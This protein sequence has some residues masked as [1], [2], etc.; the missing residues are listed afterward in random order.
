MFGIKK[1]EIRC[2]ITTLQ[3]AK[4]D[5]V[6]GK[7][8]SAL[9]RNYIICMDEALFAGDRAAIDN[10]KS[11][12][13]EQYLHIE[14]KFQPSRSIESV[15]R[16]FAASNHDHFAHVESDDRRCLVNLRKVSKQ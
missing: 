7:F 15:H 12:V 14:Q 10:L 9:E 8:T 3:V 1:L 13:T 2:Q 11:I 6:V 4:I 5:Q 16:L